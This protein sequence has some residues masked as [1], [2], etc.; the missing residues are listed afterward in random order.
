MQD[1]YSYLVDALRAMPIVFQALLQGCTQEQAQA[2]RGGDDGWSV[3]EVVCHLRDNEERVLERMRLMRDE[4]DPFIAAYD[5]EQW[6]RERNYAADNLRKALAAFVRLRTS[7]IAELA[8]LTPAEWERTG[9]H[10]ERGRITISNQTLR[11]VCHDT[12]HA[13]QLARQLGQTSAL[14]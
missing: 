5:Q 3:L 11:V 6:A 10:Q 2:L 13:A 14:P 8:A 4:A 7:H 12:I 1:T 9:Q